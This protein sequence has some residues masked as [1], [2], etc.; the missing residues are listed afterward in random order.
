MV[1]GYPADALF[2]GSSRLFYDY[3]CMANIGLAQ[4]QAKIK[5][6]SDLGMPIYIKYPINYPS[7]MEDDEQI[8]QYIEGV[9]ASNRPGF[10]HV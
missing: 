10:L 5:L 2:S 1:L 6:A 7:G 8:F 4:L 9:N 3:T